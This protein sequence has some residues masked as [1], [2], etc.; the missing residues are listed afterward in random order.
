MVSCQNYGPVPTELRAG[1]T[2]YRVL[3]SPQNPRTWHPEAPCASTP[4]PQYTARGCSGKSADLGLAAGARA[5]AKWQ[6]ATGPAGPPQPAAT[7][8]HAHSHCREGGNL[9]VELDL[10]FVGRLN[11]GGLFKQTH[12]SEGC[13]RRCPSRTRRTTAL[14]LLSA[15]RPGSFARSAPPTPKPAAILFRSFLASPPAP[16]PLPSSLSQPSEETLFCG[17]SRFSVNWCHVLTTI[18]YSRILLTTR[19]LN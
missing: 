11:L 7:N 8:G 4:P 10:D 1:E 17:V 18:G 3:P 6:L 19:H 15:P 9:R 16:V 5:G 13:P 12:R 2:A 14:P